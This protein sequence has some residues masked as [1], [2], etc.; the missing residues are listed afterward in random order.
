[1][2]QTACYSISYNVHGRLKGGR[3]GLAPL[4]DF[5]NV[6]KKGCFLNFDWGKPNFITFGAPW[7]ILEKILPT[8]IHMLLLSE[9]N[10]KHLH[11]S[12]KALKIIFICKPGI[13]TDFQSFQVRMMNK[14]GHRVSLQSVLR[15]AF[16]EKTFD[17][18]FPTTMRLNKRRRYNFSSFKLWVCTFVYSAAS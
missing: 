9:S 7:K 8:P 14:P 17:S 15:F 1:M 12:I 10:L 13:L 18:T 4:L 3:R 11:Y 6:R 16:L 5:E 2:H